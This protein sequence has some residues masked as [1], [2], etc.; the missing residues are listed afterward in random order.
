MELIGYAARFHV[1]SSYSLEKL[2]YESK[3]GSINELIDSDRYSVNLHTLYESILFI[4]LLALP[5]FAMIIVLVTYLEC[6]KNVI[7]NMK[8][9]QVFLT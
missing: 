4:S 6:T 7:H 1:N 9:Y 2:T 3:S 5:L 8:I